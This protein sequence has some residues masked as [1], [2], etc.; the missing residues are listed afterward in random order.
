MVDKL[1]SKTKDTLCIYYSLRF[2]PVPSGLAAARSVSFSSLSLWFYCFAA[3]PK[4]L[5]NNSTGPRLHRAAKGPQSS[6]F[7]RERA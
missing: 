1:P 6:L 7:V 5:S 3:N 2:L 4:G